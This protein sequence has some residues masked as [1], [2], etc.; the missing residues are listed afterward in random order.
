MTKQFQSGKFQHFFSWKKNF[1]PNPPPTNGALHFEPGFL[2]LRLFFFLVFPAIS[3]KEGAPSWKANPKFP[4]WNFGLELLLCCRWTWIEAWREHWDLGFGRPRSNPDPQG[5]SCSAFL[6]KGMDPKPAA[7]AQGSLEARIFH[8]CVSLCGSGV[9]LPPCQAWLCSLLRRV[10]GT[11]DPFVAF[12]G[13]SGKQPEVKS[14]CSKVW[15][16]VIHLIRVGSGV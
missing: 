7:C 16:H 15:E 9:F 6:G 12:S 8:G 10:V 13:K 3:G 4:L 14:L 5:P 1:P 11:K 2:L